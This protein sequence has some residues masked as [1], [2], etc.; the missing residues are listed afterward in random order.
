MKAHH[1]LE[2][3]MKNPTFEAYRVAVYMD[4]GS[5]RYNDAVVF[6]ET[7]MEFQYYRKRG[8]NADK[9]LPSLR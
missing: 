6:T 5:K 4:L 3:A 2:L 8:I 1:Y 9:V 7:A